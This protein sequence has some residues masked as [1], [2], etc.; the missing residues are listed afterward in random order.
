MNFSLKQLRAFIAVGESKS[1][2]EAALSLHASQSTISLMIKN[3]E[4]ELGLKLLDRTTRQV[5][6]S[7]SGRDFFP[8]AQKVLDDI[9]SI[10]K[11]ATDLTL[12]KR[13]VLRICATEA[14]TCSLLAPAIAEYSKHRPG[15]EVRVVDTLSHSMFK[16]L[17][18]GEVDYLIGPMSLVEPTTDL[19]IE[20]L[21]ES[22]MMVW[23][24]SSHPLV[25]RIKITGQ[26][27]LGYGVIVPS[28]DFS[29]RFLP[30]LREFLGEEMVEQVLATAPAP[31]QVTNLFTGFSLAQAGLGIAIA[32]DYI[33]PL[34]LQFGLKSCL[35]VKPEMSRVVALFTR[36]N[37]ALSP[38][39]LD[40]A[41]FLRGF[42]KA[43]GLKY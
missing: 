13:A 4:D 5:Q 1:F 23:C 37:H 6:L 10:K 14:V 28:F 29:T 41:D 32:A 15:I 33:R 27:I 22:P 7:D 40:F 11:N 19:E 20:P 35:L 31:R 26:D 16:T 30:R 25:K 2:T 9:Q 17:R 39:A 21:L 34:A 18:N 38:P 3:L 36:R 24:N 42:L 8:L 12:L 43:R